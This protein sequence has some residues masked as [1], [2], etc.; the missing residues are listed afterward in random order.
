MRSSILQLSVSLFEE[1]FELLLNPRDYLL[2]LVQDAAL[3]KK[4]RKQGV[5]VC[6]G[7]RPI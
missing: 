2:V 3:A 7:V 5:L 1:E 4:Q 6:R